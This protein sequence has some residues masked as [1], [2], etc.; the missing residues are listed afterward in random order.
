VRAQAARR[1][2]GLRCGG[3][4]RLRSYKL[5][6]HK[7]LAMASV[8]AVGTMSIAA[9]ARNGWTA[10]RLASH[11]ARRVASLACCRAAHHVLNC[12]YQPCPCGARPTPM[13]GPHVVVCPCAAMAISFCWVLLNFVWCGPLNPTA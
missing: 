2:H 4:I 11:R 6:S 9:S 7:A 12:A 10:S 8:Y 5:S 13:Y 1:W 3:G